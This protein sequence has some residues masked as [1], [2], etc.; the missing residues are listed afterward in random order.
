MRAFAIPAGRL[1]D[2]LLVYAEQAG[3]SIALGDPRLDRLRTGGLH[4]RYEIANALTRLLQGSDL[5]FIFTDAATIRLVARPP[6]RK[7]TPQPPPPRRLGPPPTVNGEEIVVIATKQQASLADYPASVSL[8]QLAL[9][10]SARG[11]NEG[12]G[13]VLTRLPGLASTNLGPGRNK[14]FIRGVA[15]SSFNGESQ[16][17]ISQ[18]LGE[19]RLIY[20]A[21]DPNL[22]LYDIERVEVLE[23]PQGTL[24]GAGTLGGIIRLLPRAPD[25][26]DPS[27]AV[28]AGTRFTEHGAPG[29]DIAG[30]ANL[31]IVKGK[32]GARAVAYRSIEGGYIDDVL[33]GRADINRN[34]ISGLR[35][36][37][38]WTP[39]R[40]WTIDA[41]VVSQDLGSRDGQYAE[42]EIGELSRRSAIAQPFDNDYRLAY[43]TVTRAWGNTQLVSASS[44]TRHTIETVFDAT[45]DPGVTT[46]RM[47]TEDGAIR[48]FSHETRVS[49]KL[50]TKG[51]WLV[52]AS[53]VHNIDRSSR[54]LGDLG[55]PQ[56]LASVANTTL[57]SALVG[58]AAAPIIGTIELTLGGR[59]SYVRQT[60]EVTGEDIGGSFE[61]RRRQFRTLPTTAL[62]W[63]RPGF[64]VYGRYQEGYRPGALQ[65]SG[66][67]D[68]VTAQHFERDHIRTVE[69]GLRFGTRPGAALSGS[70]AA[71]S[72]AWSDIQA[73]LVEADGLPF[74]ANIGS[75]RVRNLAANVSWRPLAGLTLDASGFIASSS[76]SHP[77]PGFDTARDRDLPNIADE[78]WRLGARYDRELCRPLKA[79]GAAAVRPAAGELLRSRGRRAAVARAIR[80]VARHRQPARFR[81]QYVRLRQS[82]PAR[83]GR[84]EHATA[85]ALDPH[86][87]GR[88]L[89]M[90]RLL[91]S[92][93]DVAP[94]FESEVDQLADLLSGLV[95]GPRLAMLVVPD[96]WDKSPI[97]AAPA[98][99]ARLRGWAEAGVEMFVHGWSHRDTGHHEGTA[100][101]KA[102]HMTAGE[103]EFLGLSREEAGQR[104]QAGCALIEEV[105]GRAAAGFIA[106]AWLYGE[107][108]LAAAHDCG[109]AL[110]EDHFRVWQPGRE[111]RLL[112]RGP[113]VTWA[114][115]SPTRTASSLAFAALA[116]HALHRL[117][118]VRIAVHPG[119]VT[120]PSLLASI[121]ATVKAFA[122]QRPAG[123]YADLAIE[124]G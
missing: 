37:L 39:D 48:L 100:S 82:L 87:P 119:D 9:L 12:T 18:Y 70:L 91:L 24:Y 63:K 98:F 69:L 99:Q 31:P 108:A 116:R 88:E 64:I 75:G 66:I 25:L 59:L 16:A 33:R 114:S 121:E 104:M 89:L 81:D 124:R 109:F 57:D 54:H 11:G 21:P 42:S 97:V 22:L 86:R 72:A 85:A 44:Y 65:V 45:V 95:E 29:Y 118:I 35:A 122:A 55:D 13:Y 80:G 8:M 105:T 76:L 20:S 77:A 67:G 1:S 28:S 14:I 106:P 68:D 30:V 5:S 117:E 103:G 123:R 23:G 58:E 47:Y 84:P 46:P 101:F 27:A 96:Y 71:S 60:S 120:K 94:C 53:L 34:K 17:T 90:K 62:A 26:D 4:G 52:G 38:R 113:V 112:A 93:H 32:L 107:G 36:S 92:I 73:D 3:V 115:R 49:G 74:I 6:K 10:D 110:C 83:Q 19:A 61:P 7:L 56:L 2:A 41:G 43:A 79:G 40:D 51:R 102:R 78:G 15:D 111:D 50:G